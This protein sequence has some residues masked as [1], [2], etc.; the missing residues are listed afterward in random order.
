[1]WIDKDVIYAILA[2]MFCGFAMWTSDLILE[3]V[4]CPPCK[5][6]FFRKECERVGDRC[7]YCNERI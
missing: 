2:L 5:R 6:L 4:S 3:E 1:M 7:G